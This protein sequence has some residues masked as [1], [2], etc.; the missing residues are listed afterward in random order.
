LKSTVPFYNGSSYNVF[1]CWMNGE[2]T[3]E[4]LCEMIK[5]DPIMVAKYAKEQGLLNTPG[6]KKLQK[7]ACRI[8]KFLL[9]V[10]HA[11][12]QRAPCGVRFKF[13]V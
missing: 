4:L 2:E 11:N 6:W 1:I 7:F 13:G 8:K 10:K 5:D 12:L 3:Y 9:M